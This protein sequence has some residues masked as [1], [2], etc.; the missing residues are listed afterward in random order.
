M[1]KHVERVGHAR[2]SAVGSVLLVGV[3]VG[4]PAAVLAQ[5][6]PW[7]ADDT[8]AP[9]AAT[10][11]TAATPSPTPTSGTPAG[12][13]SATTGPVTR[14]AATRVKRQKVVA[15]GPAIQRKPPPPQLTEPTT[16]RVSSFNVLGASHTT[17][18]GKHARFGPGPMRIRM[19]AS[20]FASSGIS[21]AGLQELQPSQYAAFRAAAPAWA[22]FPGTSLSRISTANSIVWRTDVWELVETHTISIPYFFGRQVPMPYVLL[23]NR[24]TG[25]TVW[26]ANFHNPADTHGP[27]QRWRDVAV[28]R[29]IGL[30]R[31]LG[32]DGTPVVMT[33]D[34]NDRERYFCPMTTQG[35]LHSASGGSVGAPCAPPA[36]MNVDWIMGSSQVSFANYSNIAGGVVARISDHPFLWADAT[37]GPQPLD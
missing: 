16:F 2:R 9:L 22:V 13:A 19:T 17:K 23:R 14:S 28:S 24:S 36:R 32:A 11:T 25:S 34:M 8:L 26:F 3:L 12:T 5:T 6:Q 33:G 21:V 37:V 4:V 15:R 10:R 20:L 18:G 7:D 31:S 35:G 30:A 1:S 27:A 29:Q